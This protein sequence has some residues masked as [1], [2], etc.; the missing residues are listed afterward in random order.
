LCGQEEQRLPHAD[1]VVDRAKLVERLVEHRDE[2]VHGEGGSA[3][4]T[5]VVSTRP[6][7]G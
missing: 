1:L 7:S 4:S 2:L 3:N 5:N 6:R